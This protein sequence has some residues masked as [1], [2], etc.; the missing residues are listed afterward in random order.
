MNTQN[1]RVVVTGG[2]SGMGR[3][4]VARL[5][6]EGAAVALLG[7]PGP[8]FDAA[9]TELSRPGRHVAACE[10]DVSDP[11]QVSNAFA[12]AERELG[13]VDGVFNNAGISTV[14]SLVET[15]DEQWQRQLQV[16]LSGNFYVLR[17]AAR[18]MRT[19]R[20]GAIVNTGSELAFI[21]QAGYVGYS[22]TKG[23]ILAMTRSAAAELAQYG[24]R[25]NSVCP[26]AIDTPLLRAE[27][28]QAEDPAAEL[29]GNEHSIVWGRI[30]RPQEVASAV[31]FLLSDAASYITGTHLIVDG[32]RVGCFPVG[33]LAHQADLT[34]PG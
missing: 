24:I 26:G 16:N 28:A 7:L 33:S 13:G 27:F 22:A 3:A 6:E 10:V 18:R 15:T 30:G 21:G 19:Q 8:E 11:E 29:R 14:A 32:G 4:V 1:T 5:L 9:V 25:V 34:A 20:R 31:V 12:A 2:A 17:E 23:G